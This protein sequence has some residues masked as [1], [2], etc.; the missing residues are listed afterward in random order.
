ML[1]SSLHYTTPI[2]VKLHTG[3]WFTVDAQ[4]INPAIAGTL[5][6]DNSYIIFCDTIPRNP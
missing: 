1:T 6:S 4:F 5:P 2:L 3:G